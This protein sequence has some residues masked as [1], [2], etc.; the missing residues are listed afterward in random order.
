MD[1][2]WIVWHWK[3]STFFLQILME[4]SQLPVKNFEQQIMSAIYNNPVV[5]IRGATGCGKT[6]QV[7]QYILDEFIKGGRASDCNIV[8]TQVSL[9][10]CL[11]MCWPSTRRS[12]VWL[13]S[14]VIHPS[15]R[16]VS[17]QCQC[18]NVYLLRD[19]KM[20]AKAVATVCALSLSCPDLMP[21]FSSAQLVRS[22]FSNLWL[23]DTK[24]LGDIAKTF[25]HRGVAEEAGVW[26]PW[27]QS[28]DRGW[29]PWEGHKCKTTPFLFFRL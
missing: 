5:I 14:A 2:I 1:K 27:D 16:D 24:A 6:T 4:R 29:N 12:T 23:C 7:P 3:S 26:Y 17:V 8:V 21:A 28:R 10:K 20:W 11:F 22:S 13:P 19:V 9:V 15:S 25:I 18:Q